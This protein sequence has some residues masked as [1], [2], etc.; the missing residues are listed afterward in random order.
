M[1]IKTKKTY[2]IC[3]IVAAVTTLVCILDVFVRGFLPEWIQFPILAVNL[4]TAIMFGC[5]QI[6]FKIMRAVW[7]MLAHSLITMLIA[8]IVEIWIA[9]ALLLGILLFP[10]SFGIIAFFMYYRDLSDDTAISE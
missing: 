7:R 10:S 4:A 3:M 9:G 1:L 2:M 8:A 6:S 5:I